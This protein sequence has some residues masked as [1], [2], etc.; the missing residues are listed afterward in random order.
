[1]IFFLSI[2]C[3]VVLPE[4]GSHGQTGFTTLARY[5]ALP[6]GYYFLLYDK[7]VA[8]GGSCDKQQGENVEDDLL[9]W[10]LIS[11]DY[12]YLV[13]NGLILM[14]LWVSAK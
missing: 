3:S 1:M 14:F 8:C 13:L 4:S 10:K 6:I 5:F 7:F 2:L 11:N 12:I 9:W